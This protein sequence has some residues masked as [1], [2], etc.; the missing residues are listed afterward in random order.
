MDARP[1][2]P[3]QNGSHAPRRTQ[4]RVRIRHEGARREPLLTRCPFDREPAVSRL[5]GRARAM[6]FRS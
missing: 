2:P 4:A 5:S 6:R 3:P 1:F